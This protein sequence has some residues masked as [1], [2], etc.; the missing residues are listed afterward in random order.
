MLYSARKSSI[1]LLIL[2]FLVAGLV[3]FGEQKVVEASSQT[4]FP[5]AS[6]ISV[7]SPTNR[8]YTSNLLTLNAS[9]S[10]L[11]AR[12]IKISMTYSLDGMPN[13]TLPTRIHS[14]EKSL[15]ATVIGTADLSPLSCG[16]HN[17]T[18]HVKIEVTDA[19]MGGVQYSKYVHYDN[20]TVYFTIST[21]LESEIPE[22]PSSAP[23]LIILLPATIT[24][25]IY[26]HSI[27]KNNLGRT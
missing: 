5:L 2:V 20:S 24:V 16:S 15:I 23:L 9:I 26:R 22:F 25:L 11:V 19:Y 12:N 14:R 18:V 1:Q 21:I 8:T 6:G 3:L 17:I 4:D 13:N 7:K 27:R 10:S